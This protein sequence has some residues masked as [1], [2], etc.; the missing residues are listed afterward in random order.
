MSK[1][2]TLEAFPE[3]VEAKPEPTPKETEIV[4]ES[5]DKLTVEQVW[6]AF[7]QQNATIQQANA[8][9]QQ[10][11]Q[12]AQ[13]NQ[14]QFGVLIKQIAILQHSLEVAETKGQASG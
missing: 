14:D 8:A 7:Q 12:Q 13:R 4:F 2:N 11:Q 5:G 3:T 1:S 9:N 6:N 10:L